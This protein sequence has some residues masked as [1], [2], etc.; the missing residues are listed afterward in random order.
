MPNIASLLKDEIARVTR[1]EIRKAT[2]GTKR[3]TAQYRRDIATLK[4]Q[5]KALQS[6]VVLLE[7]KILAKPVKAEAKPGRAKARFSP[8]YLKAQRKRLGLSVADYATLADVSAATIY[9]WESG[10]TRPRKEQ[11][12]TLAA[13]RGLGKREAVARVKLLSKK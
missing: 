1:K 8:T 9:N 7:K 3:A 2:A 11:I 4:R 13:L 10:K 12:A 5:V 6:T